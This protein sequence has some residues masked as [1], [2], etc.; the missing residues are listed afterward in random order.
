[1]ETAHI[2][3]CIFV[4]QTPPQAP[5]FGRGTSSPLTLAYSHPCKNDTK[6][7][8]DQFTPTGLITRSFTGT[9]NG[10]N[11]HTIFQ[12]HYFNF[13]FRRHNLRQYFWCT[14]LHHPGQGISKT[15]ISQ[16]I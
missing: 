16:H 5:A 7:K 13:S 9:F 14:V 10:N 1:M 11:L 12:F 3:L 4:P 6:V 8:L 2:A 15:I